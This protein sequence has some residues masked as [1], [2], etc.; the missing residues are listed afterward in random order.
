MTERPYTTQHTQRLLK[1]DLRGLVER[2]VDAG[3]DR[4]DCVGRNLLRES[5]ELFRLGGRGFG[6]LTRMRGRQFNH[7]GERLYRQ[8]LAEEVESTVGISARKF[9]HL[10]T[11]L[12]SAL[13]GGGI[14]VLENVGGLFRGSL[15]LLVAVLR[16]GDALLGEFTE[17]SGNFHL[18]NFELR[19]IELRGLKACGR[20]CG[21]H[22][23]QV[24]DDG[25]RHD[26]SLGPLDGTLRTDALWW[27]TCLFTSPRGGEL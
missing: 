19:H 20:L 4:L 1:T 18:G 8:Q 3:F 9:D 17:R 10:A 15:D 6:L 2:A 16:L 5:G 11:V 24:T 13:G 7:L 23:F 12:G 25:F 26:T 27:V 21:L 14:G 22:Y